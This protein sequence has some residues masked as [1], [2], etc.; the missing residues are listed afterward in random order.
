MQGR[1]ASQN[2]P[3]EHYLLL[4][5]YEWGVSDWHLDAVRPFLK[6]Y[7][8]AVGFSVEEARCARRVTV[9]GGP[10]SFSEDEIHSLRRSGCVVHQIRGDGTDIA[11]ELSR[12]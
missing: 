1:F 4:P 10:P 7:H 2:K 11:S 5:S 9:V 8:P 3:I 12:M 6:K